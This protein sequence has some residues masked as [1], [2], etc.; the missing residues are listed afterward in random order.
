[1]YVKIQLVQFRQESKPAAADW[2]ESGRDWAGG[3]D[4]TRSWPVPGTGDGNGMAYVHD[5]AES[6]AGRVG[7]YTAEAPDVAPTSTTR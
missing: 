7:L 1:M 6:V 3:Q 4:D 2:A 5:T